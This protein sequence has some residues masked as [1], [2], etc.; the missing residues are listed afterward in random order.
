MAL[1]SFPSV[2]ETAEISSDIPAAVKQNQ[3]G[4]NRKL[5]FTPPAE[6]KTHT[7]AC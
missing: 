5:K 1:K 6:V 2:M 4:I 3:K 7:P